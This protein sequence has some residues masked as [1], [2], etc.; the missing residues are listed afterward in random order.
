MSNRITT[1]EDITEVITKGTTPTTL[2]FEFS[3]IG[4]P[5][6]RVQNIY[7]GM[8]H[9]KQDTLFINNQTHNA[10]SRSKIQP[11]DILVSIAG[12]IGRAGVVPQ[13][14]PSLNC[15]QAIAIIRP[16]SQVYGPFLRLWLENSNSQSQMRGATVKGTI[17]NLS[18]TQLR[19]LRINLPPLPEQQRIAAILDQAETLRTMRRTALAKIDT[20]AQS[21]F[22]DMF[23]DPIENPKGWERIPFRDLLAGIESGWSPNCLDRPAGHGEWGVLKL[24]AATKCEFCETE[25]KALPQG[26][27]PRPEIEVKPGDL[28]F[29]R[30]NTYDLVA[31][32]ALVRQTRPKLMISDLFFRLRLR[33]TAMVT[34]GYL[35][36]LLVTRSKRESIQRLAGGS[37]GSMPNISKGKLATVTI[38]VP[39]I[40]L[41]RRFDELSDAIWEQIQQQRASHAHLDLLFSSLQHQAFR[42]YL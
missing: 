18:L 38:E 33:S 11:G 20:L 40:E 3:E 34:P 4:T 24:G 28:L 8:V 32:C 12:T 31:A 30:K 1:L 14:A 2:G 5:F 16:T 6:L 39:P 29:T 35:Q 17:S 9:Y 26:E 27:T 23:G 42:G 15:N 25:Q 13:D 7:N 22:I 19:N 21:I 37:A 36:Q 10:L 41:Q